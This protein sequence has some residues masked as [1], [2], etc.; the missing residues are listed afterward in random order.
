MLHRR[1]GRQMLLASLDEGAPDGTT[2]SAPQPE[3][4]EATP[5]HRMKSGVKVCVEATLYPDG[6]AGIAVSRIEGSAP[7][8]RVTQADSL[9]L[10]DRR[11][12]EDF[13]EAILDRLEQ[14]AAQ[15]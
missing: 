13:L 14:A 1:S 12:L 10:N 15:L 2:A 11:E 8:R 6:H 7:T 3:L 4:V 5:I 9:P